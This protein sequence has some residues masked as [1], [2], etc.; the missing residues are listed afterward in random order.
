MCAQFALKAQANDLSLRFKIKVPETLIEINERFLPYKKAPVVVLNSHG[1]N[2]LVTMN[3]SLVPGWSEEPK[4]KFATHNARLETVTE[5]PTWKIPFEKKHCLIPLTSF[6]ESVYE[7]PLQG[8][9]I[10]FS[11]KE[12]QILWAAGIFDYWKKADQ[13]LFSFSILTTTPDSF[14]LDHGHDRSP[15]FLNYTDGL[16][17]LSLA[18]QPQTSAPDMVR[19]LSQKLIRPQLNVVTDRPLKAGW[20]KR[21]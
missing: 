21:K 11:D 12:H 3:F 13:D 1:E 14:I 9:I 7:G 19:F 4:V 5:K 15:L 2:Q 20:E 8:N 17:W 10:E 18:K 16:N 6:Y